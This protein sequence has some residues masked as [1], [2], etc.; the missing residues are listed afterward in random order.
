MSHLEV[1]YA[2]WKHH[3]GIMT[4]MLRA[5][6][7]GRTSDSFFVSRYK[8]FNVQFSIAIKLSLNIFMCVELHGDL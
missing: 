3:G 7:L 5:I 8:Y 6:L 1:T 2:E 4:D